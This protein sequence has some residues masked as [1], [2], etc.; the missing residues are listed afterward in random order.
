MWCPN[1]VIR[2]V[3]GAPAPMQMQAT[4]YRSNAV[5]NT[6]NAHGS[7]GKPVGVQAMPQHP[8][9]DKNPG[10]YLPQGG[11]CPTQMPPPRYSSVV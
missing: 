7:Y 9:P 10:T 8:G 4:S 3:H 1:V 11:A 5:S 2:A 6:S